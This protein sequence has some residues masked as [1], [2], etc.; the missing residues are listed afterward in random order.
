MLNSLYY[1][2][3]AP[4]CTCDCC[5]A[6]KRESKVTC[7]KSSTKAQEVSL[8]IIDCRKKLYVKTAAVV[9][10]NMVSFGKENECNDVMAALGTDMEH[11]LSVGADKK[12]EINTKLQELKRN[13]SLQDRD[14]KEL[15]SNLALLR[16]KYDK[17]L[18][19]L[20]GQ[21]SL[22]DQE[23]EELKSDMA[24]LRSKHD[25]EL[26]ELKGHL[27]LKDQEL[28]GLLKSKLLSL[29]DIIAAKD[30]TNQR[31][32]DIN[33]MRALQRRGP[34][35]SQAAYLTMEELCRTFCDP[36]AASTLAVVDVIYMDENLNTQCVASKR[37][38]NGYGQ[39]AEQHA[40][41]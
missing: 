16:S 30:G 14:L 37:F 13:L 11:L 41:T 24:L 22:K 36:F 15:K 4:A 38:K 7:P 12:L 5:L 17:E 25:E 18:E 29:R 2:H 20:K 9:E 31:R 23:V 35:F 40:C 8:T 28:D 21:L 1:G 32:K 10:S 26:E 34:H 3:L 27:S 33:N 39:H 19:E 6:F